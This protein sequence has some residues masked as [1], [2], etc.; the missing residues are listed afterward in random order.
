MVRPLSN[1]DLARLIGFDGGKR[2]HRYKAR[3]AFAHLDADG[4]IDLRRD[5]KGVRIFGP[6]RAR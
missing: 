3:N 6:D 4:V 2:D 5:G 1:S